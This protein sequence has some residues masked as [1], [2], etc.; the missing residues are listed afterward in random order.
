MSSAI[1]EEIEIEDM[2][3][4]FEEETNTLIF[5][6]PCPCG[7]KFSI[8]LDELDDGEDIGTCPSCTLRIRVIYDEEFVRNKKSALL[9][10]LQTKVGQQRQEEGGDKI[11]SEKIPTENGCS[12]GTVVNS[13]SDGII[14]TP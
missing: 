8:T 13:S 5:I 9:L 3:E 2:V 7:D 6:Y 14:N 4:Q 12:H 10:L 1:Y 11:S